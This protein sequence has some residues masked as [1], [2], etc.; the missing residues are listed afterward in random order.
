VCP[1]SLTD[2][3]DCLTRADYD[4]D[5]EYEGRSNY[6]FFVDDTDYATAYESRDAV[7]EHPFLALKKLLN[8]GSFYY[9]VDFDLTNRLQDR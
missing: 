4:S 2:G 1:I 5:L 3:I 8:D 9:S 7:I 6:G